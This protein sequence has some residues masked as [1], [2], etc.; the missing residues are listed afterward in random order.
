MAKIKA[1]NSEYSG[2]IG[3]VRFVDGEAETDNQAVINYCRTAGY[4]VDGS[5]DTENPPATRPEAL[6]PDPREH[7]D[8][9]LGTRLR[10]A[11]VDPKPG[12]F[13]P[14]TNAGAEGELG[15]PHGPH[16]VAPGIHA[17][18]TGPIVPGPV[19]DPDTQ[20]DRETRVAERVFVDNEDVPTVT[21]EA[22]E[23]VGQPAPTG[24]QI[25][26]EKSEHAEK[27][28]ANRAET[29]EGAPRGNASLDAW[30]TYSMSVDP[31]LTEEAARELGRDSLR[32]RYA[33]K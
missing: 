1:P 8:E 31:E 32:E 3:D 11:A 19:G 21:Q 29:S 5:T 14:P 12:D 4:E 10:D 33:P 15:N 6:P 27:V 22:G 17:S 23:E 16:V 9:V 28:E 30:V 13:L 25:A 7:T 24:E 26:A 2:T 20:Q 18:E